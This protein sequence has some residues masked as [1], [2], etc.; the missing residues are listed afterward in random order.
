MYRPI[1][2]WSVSILAN[3]LAHILWS[4]EVLCIYWNYIFHSTHKF[5]KDKRKFNLSSLN[6]ALQHVE[7]IFICF[8][9]STCDWLKVTTSLLLANHKHCLQ[10]KWRSTLHV[11]VPYG[12]VRNRKQVVNKPLYLH[13]PVCPRNSSSYGNQKVLMRRKNIMKKNVLEMFLLYKY[14]MHR[15]IWRVLVGPL[16][17]PLWWW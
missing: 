12:K 16:I 1:D 4:I 5:S 6:K 14:V 11:E 8:S 2:T 9:S 7:S 10:N 15:N 17:W 3:L 13:S